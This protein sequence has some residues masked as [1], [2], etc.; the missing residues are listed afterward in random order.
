MT[1]EIAGPSDVESRLRQAAALV[2]IGAAICVSL[3]ACC[4]LTGWI[5]DIAPFKTVVP[6][7]T[8]MKANTALEFLFSGASLALLC[9]PKF[10]RIH[11]A[12]ALLVLAIS[13]LS[14]L[15][16]ASGRS[17]GID[18]LAFPDSQSPQ[19]PGRMA[20][21]TAASFIV[22][23]AALL[24]HGGKPLFRIAS[25][26]LLL[27]AS[28]GPTLGIVGYLYGIPLLYGSIHYT[29]MA[30]HTG[31]GLL[32]LILG[33]LFTDSERGFVRIFLSD[34][35]GGF[36]A[37][38]VVPAAIL[39]PI[40]LGYLF[41]H[42]T[43]NF[44]EPRLGSALIVISNSAVFAA[45][46]WTIAFHLQARELQWSRSERDANVDSLTGLM[47]RR[48]FEK[49]LKEEIH[50]SERYG[51]KFSLILFDVDHFKALN[52]SMGHM[53]GDQVLHSVA[54]IVKAGLRE[55]DVTC[56]FGGEEFVVIVV[57]TGGND[58][59]YA[60]EK[61]RESVESAR[62]EGSEHL[63]MTVSAGISNYPRDGANR[64]QLLK[65][66]DIALYKAKTSGRN[67]VVSFAEPRTTVGVPLAGSSTKRAG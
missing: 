46:I 64:G 13:V 54:Q 24:L 36:L 6:G 56:R 55:T 41:I 57:Q 49:R 22:V 44:H 14:L 11:H 18:Q 5:F 10:Q 29:A 42:G 20:P 60:A 31:A 21:L 65:A 47:N 45:L 38:V 25:Q 9:R 61:L 62:F 12:L 67:R 35:S 51:G 43:F 50:R 16:Y 7:S 26:A 52:D 27:A 34:T 1:P 17:F 33:I 53:I 63:R 3:L 28:F 48:Y 66:A 59:I 37:R 2:P 23:A 58:A 19:Y 30:F 8:S 32:I 40:L 39:A 4:V 15:E